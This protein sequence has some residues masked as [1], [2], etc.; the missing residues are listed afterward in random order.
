MLTTHGFPADSVD[1]L[2]NDDR[3][4]LLATRLETLIAGER[5]FMAE[6]NVTLPAERTAPAI[7]DSEASDDE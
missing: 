3:E 2:R 7:A 1:R 6:R 4:G 5:Q